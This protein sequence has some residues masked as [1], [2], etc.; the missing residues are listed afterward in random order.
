M[1]FQQATVEAIRR[2]G[3]SHSEVR[4]LY[5]FGS[6]ASG[7]PRSDSDLDV[8]VLYASPSRLEATVRFEEELEQGTGCRV[9]LVDVARAGAFLA[10]EI[11]RGERVF[12]REST[13]TDGF[14][15]YVLARAGDLLPFE[16]QRQAL[17]LNDTR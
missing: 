4:A 16:R 5:L 15:L 14:E 12:C 13:E 1:A 17:L 10:L 3:R 9:D 7:E 11:V 2:V 8:G 6:Q